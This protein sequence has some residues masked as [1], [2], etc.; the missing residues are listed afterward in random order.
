VDEN[1]QGHKAQ[2]TWLLGAT[3]DVE[4]VTANNIT[5][6]AT[7]SPP[8]VSWPQKGGPNVAGS[9]N[10]EPCGNI[11]PGSDWLGRH[12]ECT[13]PP[14]PS[15]TPPPSG[16]PNHDTAVDP[17]TLA[18]VGGLVPLARVLKKRRRERAR[19]C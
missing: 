12:P 19:R 2:L 6:N 15:P 14:T 11:P 3:L 10:D 5:V 7:V 13:P 9:P 8:N 4:A 1:G 18:M 16:G 17:L